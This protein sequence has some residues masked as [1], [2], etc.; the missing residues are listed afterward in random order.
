MELNHKLSRVVTNQKSKVMSL[1]EEHSFSLKLCHDFDSSAMIY[2]N[3]VHLCRSWRA[4]KDTGVSLF[5]SSFG[6]AIH[7]WDWFSSHGYDNSG[8]RQDHTSVCDNT[9]LF[10]TIY[11]C[12]VC[13]NLSYCSYEHLYILG[14]DLTVDVCN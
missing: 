6:Q 7:N 4:C 11:I 10:V 5:F 14:A 2:S 12:C 9:D 3:I 8:F 1:L 13:A